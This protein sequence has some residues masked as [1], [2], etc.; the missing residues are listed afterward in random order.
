[1]NENDYNEKIDELKKIVDRY[2]GFALDAPEDG[3]R[4]E[5]DLREALDMPQVEY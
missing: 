2:K 1:M 4:L 3:W 5:R